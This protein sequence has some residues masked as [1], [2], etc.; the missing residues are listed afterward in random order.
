[1]G[2]TK[3]YK[4]VRYASRCAQDDDTVA[5]SYF[6]PCQANGTTTVTSA[7]ILSVATRHE[8]YLQPS[9]SN[10]H[11]FDSVFFHGDNGIWLH[12]WFVAQL[13]AGLKNAPTAGSFHVERHELTNVG[14]P[15]CRMEEENHRRNPGA[16]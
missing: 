1:M 8:K 6:H 3:S 13:I 2:R 15:S 11:T 10:N 7:D 4:V 9:A 16:D 5:R 12:T 14:P